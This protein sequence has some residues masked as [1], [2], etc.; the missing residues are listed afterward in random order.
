MMD[1]GYPLHLI[2]LLAKLYRKQLAKVKVAGTLSEWFRV[3]K[4][5]RQDCVRGRVN[6]NDRG[7]GQMEKVRPWCGQASDRERLENRIELEG[8]RCCPILRTTSMG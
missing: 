4:G 7:Q 6:Q 8:L 1:M 2:D 5:V 3:K